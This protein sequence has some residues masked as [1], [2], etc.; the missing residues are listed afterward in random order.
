M[1]RQNERVT[2]LSEVV[3]E[4][5]SGKREARINDLSAGGCYV[6]T[7]ATVPQGEPLQLELKDSKGETMTFSGVVAY[8]LAGFGIGVKFVNLTDEQ[9]GFLDR[10]MGN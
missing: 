1:P 3:L 6:E 7:I 9:K 4:W 5:S 2:F 8:G 10:I